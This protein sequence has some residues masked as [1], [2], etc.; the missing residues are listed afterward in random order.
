MGFAI[1]FCSVSFQMHLSLFALM[2]GVSM[3][4]IHTA[5]LL[6]LS[7]LETLFSFDGNAR[8]LPYTLVTNSR[9][10]IKN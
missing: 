5:P 1:I 7:L 3:S 9:T 10:A 8:I 6:V 2:N 4:R